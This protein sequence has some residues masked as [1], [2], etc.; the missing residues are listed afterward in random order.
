[1][2][3]PSDDFQELRRL[4]ALKRHE[5]P[6]PR[7]FNEFSSRV[8]DRIRTPEVLPR[9]TIWQRLGLDF[10]F[11][12]AMVCAMGVVMSALFLAGIIASPRMAV[13]M[14]GAPVDLSEMTWGAGSLYATESA[15][16]HKPI[17]SL[18][19]VPSSTVPVF[20]RPAS[21]PFSYLAVQAS[22]VSWSLDRA[23]N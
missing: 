13:G 18:D 10:D 19:E 8:I 14:G 5:Q 16:A 21:S 1:M 3:T 11:K 22:R 15:V 23:Q 20:A 7:Y 4:L 9:P 17:A 2:N 6:P 12:P